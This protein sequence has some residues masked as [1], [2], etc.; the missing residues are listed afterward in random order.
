MIVTI[1]T[2]DLF[3]MECIMSQFCYDDR[4]YCDLSI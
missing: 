1:Y 2:V 4:V 3:D